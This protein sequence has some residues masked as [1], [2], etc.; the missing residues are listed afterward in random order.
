MGGRTYNLRWSPH[1]QTSLAFAR[2]VNS[3]GAFFHSNQGGDTTCAPPQIACSAIIDDV[4]RGGATSRKV[5]L[6]S[7]QQNC[8]SAVE[9]AFEIAGSGEVQSI[10]KLGIALRREGYALNVLTG[11]L[12]LKQLRARILAVRQSS[13]GMKSP[14]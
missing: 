4:L 14:K 5:L 13:E 8:K 3:L 10:E 6:L 9:R 7:Q 1:I 2:E 11:P 12:L